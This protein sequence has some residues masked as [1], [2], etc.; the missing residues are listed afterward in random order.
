MTISISIACGRRVWRNWQLTFDF[1]VLL[2]MFYEMFTWT[3]RDWTGLTVIV[4]RQD[5]RI[6]KKFREL[7][8]GYL[9]DVVLCWVQKVDARRCLSLTFEFYVFYERDKHWWTRCRLKEASVHLTTEDGIRTPLQS[10]TNRTP[11]CINCH[12]SDWWPLFTRFYCHHHIV[13]I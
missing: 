3:G 4:V 1:F 11:H 12:R 8:V 5:F 7:F 9:G 10:V 6:E 2:V 13:C